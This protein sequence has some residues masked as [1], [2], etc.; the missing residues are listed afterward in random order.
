M[1]DQRKMSLKNT[2]VCMDLGQR[3]IFIDLVLFSKF[4][5]ITM[6]KNPQPLFKLQ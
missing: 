1:K 3:S 4:D 5:K 2:T 6:H